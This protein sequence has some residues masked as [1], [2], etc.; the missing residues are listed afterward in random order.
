MDETIYGLDFG[1]N[2]PTALIEVGIKDKNYYLRERLYKSGLTN[3]ALIRQMES[4]GIPKDCNLYADSAEPA[5]IKEIEEAGWRIYEAEKSVSDGIDFCQRQ[6]F[7]SLPENDNLH[8]ERRAYKWKEDRHGNIIDE[9][10][11][12]MDHLMDA[13]RYAIYT[14]SRTMEPKIRIV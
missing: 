3:A 14:H 2:N 12:F 8:K 5:R 1:F 10:V 11:K 4:L 13:M 6:M 7:K 9:P